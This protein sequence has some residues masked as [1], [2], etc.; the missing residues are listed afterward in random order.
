MY[1]AEQFVGICLDLYLD[2]DLNETKKYI[3][4][5]NQDESKRFNLAD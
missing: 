1:S 5:L 4:E 2:L 3:K